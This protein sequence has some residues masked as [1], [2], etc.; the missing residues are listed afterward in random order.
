MQGSNMFLLYTDGNNNVTIS[1]RSGTGYVA[2]Q[3]NPDADVELLAGSGIEN[4]M[5]TANFRCGN[6]DSWSGGSMQFSDTRSNWIYA[7]REGDALD[8]TD[9][10]VGISR[11]SSQPSNYQLDLTQATVS[12]DSNPFVDGG[13]SSGG[14]NNNSGGGSGSGGSGGSGSN[15]GQ[16]GGSGSGAITPGGSSSGGPSKIVVAHWAIMLVVWVIM[17]PLGSALMPLLGKWAIHAAWQAVAFVLMWVGFGL[18]YVASQRAG[19]VSRPPFLS[20]FPRLSFLAVLMSHEPTIPM[21]RP[22]RLTEEQHRVFKPHTPPSAPYL[23][24]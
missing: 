20:N 4:N 22:V 19:F 2:P 16:N 7:W 1:P 9:T 5:M 12:G 18:G 8:T 24:A 17:Y 21:I 6:C 14:G 3:E 23:C 10:N 15:S 11:H 13:G